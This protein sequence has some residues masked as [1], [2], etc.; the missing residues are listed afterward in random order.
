MIDAANNEPERL[1]GPSPVESS[2]STSSIQEEQ[3]ETIGSTIYDQTTDFNSFLSAAAEPDDAGES[4]EATRTRSEIIGST[5]FDQTTDFN[6]LLSGDSEDPEFLSRRRQ[7]LETLTENFS[8]AGGPR[9]K[10]PPKNDA[11]RSAAYKERQKQKDPGWAARTR[12][13]N[14]NSQRALRAKRAKARRL[15]EARLHEIQDSIPAER[16]SSGAEGE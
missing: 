2:S 13:R 5:V 4:Q 7:E 11:E 6:S 8:S 14:R 16:R 9:E 1:Q 12:E 15:A 10:R 3:P